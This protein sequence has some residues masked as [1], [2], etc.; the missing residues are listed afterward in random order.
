M[1]EPH[2]EIE[3]LREAIDRHNYNYYVLDAPEVSDAEYDALLRRLEALESQHPE[4]VT[5]VSPTQRVGTPPESGFAEASHA[6]PMLS[7]ANARDEEE[8]RA[9]DIRVRGLLG[10]DAVRYVAEPKLEVSRSN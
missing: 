5:P 6:V 7:L 4:L 2:L 9:F 1:G 3:R 8:L 10:A